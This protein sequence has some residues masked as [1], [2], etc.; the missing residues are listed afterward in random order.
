MKRIYL[1]SAL[2]I[3]GFVIAVG[4]IVFSSRPA[5][6]KTQDI[7]AFQ[8][9]F[10]SY[11]AGSGIVEA[12][13]GNITIGTPVSGIVMKVYVQIGDHVRTGDPLFKID[14][15][16]LQAQL[17]TAD[18]KVKEAEAALQKP[19]HRLENAERFVKMNPEGISKQGMADL[20]DDVTQAEAALTLAKAELAQTKMD[21]HRHTVRAPVAGQIMQL[22]MR[23]G[24]FVEASSTSPSLL[25]LGGNSRLN[26]RVDIDENDAWRVN[27]NA[28]AFAYVRGH[29]ETK[30][31][32]R[33]EYTEPHMVPK[34]DLT[35]QVTEQTDIRV[36]QV[37]YSFAP[38]GLPVYTGQ[39][40]DVYI[41]VPPANGDK[42][43][44]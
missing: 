32:L 4:A 17:L 42:G 18:A 27:K 6:V 26:V 10:A 37:V 5:K 40:L 13:T 39:Q 24:E 20:R 3:A 25:V 36:L 2:A 11:V 21:I 23:P 1:F 41:E 19:K 8:P 33:Y 7:T 12:S 31:L 35:G 14:D 22:R 34:T 44:H 30:I 15:R 38:A 16:E 9:P 29:P 43:K 28:E